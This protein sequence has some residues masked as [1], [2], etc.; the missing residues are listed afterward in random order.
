MPT[1]PGDHN[2][3]YIY[4][5]SYNPDSGSFVLLDADSTT[6]NV[7]AL[8]NPSNDPNGAFLFDD[9]DNSSDAD[10]DNPNIIGDRPN[11]QFTV[12]DAGV[13]SGTYRFLSAAATSDGGAF[14]DVG[15]IAQKGDLQYFFT[16]TAFTGTG[17]RNL[18]LLQDTDQAICFMAGTAIATPT[19]PANIEDLAIG[20]LVTTSEGRAAPIRWVGRQTVSTLFADELRLPVRI[21]ASALGESVPV[22]DLLVSNDHALMVEGVLVQAGALVNGITILRE[23]SVPRAFVYYH[24][25]LDDHALILAENVPAETFVDNVE[26]LAFD[27]WTEHEA[28]HPGGRSIPEMPLPRAKSHR[29]LPAAVRKLIA[30][31]IPAT[32]A[33][34]AA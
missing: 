2:F 6:P 5:V 21:K 12:T 33:A 4:Q 31:R 13:L 18:T 23:L 29:Q 7:Q 10:P 16:D 32:D 11:D 26:R 34:S 14:T 19:G 24:I 15:I 27:N 28:L 1:I 8:L 9:I 20:D 30:S 17:T 25:E 22:R 3:K